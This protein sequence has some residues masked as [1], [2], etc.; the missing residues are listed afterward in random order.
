MRMLVDADNK[1]PLFLY[2]KMGASFDDYQQAG[3]PMVQV[4]FDLENKPLVETPTEPEAWALNKQTGA[5]GSGHIE[6]DQI[7]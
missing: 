4:W 2:H 6:S 7:I 5:D 3:E 1:A